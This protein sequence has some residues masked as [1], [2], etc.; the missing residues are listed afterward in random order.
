MN[1]GSIASPVTFSVPSAG[2]GV[3]PATA[4]AQVNAQAATLTA[5]MGSKH[6]SAVAGNITD[7]KG[8]D[9]FA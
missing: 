5:L 9:L 7:G 2:R 3:D 1:V 6:G 8:I 4:K